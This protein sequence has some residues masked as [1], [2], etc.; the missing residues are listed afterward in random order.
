MLICENW[1]YFDWRLSSADWGRRETAGYLSSDVLSLRLMTSISV[2]M[3]NLIKGVSLACGE[4]SKISAAILM[5][6]AY[7]LDFSGWLPWWKSRGTEAIWRPGDT[8]PWWRSF[9]ELSHRL[10]GEAAAAAAGWMALSFIPEN[11]RVALGGFAQDSW[12]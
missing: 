12:N 11:E 5:H 4:P 7:W 10:T 8:L 6:A 9:G 1:S 3:C 2:W